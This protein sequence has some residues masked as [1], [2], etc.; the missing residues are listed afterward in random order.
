MRNSIGR[1]LSRE[2][3]LVAL[4]ALVISACAI[5][6]GLAGA[7]TEPDQQNPPPSAAIYDPDPNHLWNRILVVFYRQKIANNA[8]A[9]TDALWSGRVEEPRWVGPDVLDPPLGY[10]PKFL[11]NDEPFAKCNALLD[12]FISRHGA[13]LIHD[14]L[15]RALLQRDLWAVFDVLAQAGQDTSIPMGAMEFRVSAPAPLPASLEKHRTILERKLAQVIRSLALSREEIGSLPD[16]YAAAI[17]SGAFSDVLESNRYNFLPHS[18]FPTNSGWHEILPVHSF[19]QKVPEVLEHTVVAGG[20]SVFRVFVKPLDDA[21]HTNVLARYLAQEVRFREES[22]QHLEEWRQFWSTNKIARSNL[23]ESM[24]HPAEWQQVSLT[25]REAVENLDPKPAKSPRLLPWGT[26]F[27]LL[28]ELI[29]LDEEGQMV[30]SHVVESVQFHTVH[31]TGSNSDPGHMMF[32]EAELSRALLFQGQQGGLRP[33][34]AGEPRARSYNNLG[35]LRV[36][37]KGN[38]PPQKSFPRNCG[39][40]HAPGSP[41]FL[42]VAAFPTPARSV[43]VEPIVRWKQESGKLDLLSSL[44]RK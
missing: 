34:P 27:L 41:L 23:V 14:P 4:M 44:L 12:E 5:Q 26:Q 31:W 40:C 18:L 22:Q 42:R 8:S 2:V 36:D 6:G 3:G 13:T 7:Q 16:T 24:R 32:R 38:G 17:K 37:E 15:K 19:T 20:R 10:H 28:R 1:L 30:P 29:C 25:N 39:E 35:H 9:R 21:R 11:L 43:S 33:I